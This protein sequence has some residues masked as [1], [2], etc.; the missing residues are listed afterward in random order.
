LESWKERYPHSPCEAVSF[1]YRDT[2]T[3]DFVSFNTRMVVSRPFFGARTLVAHG[4]P[5]PVL[6]LVGAVVEVDVT[7]EVGR[8]R[9][10]SV[11]IAV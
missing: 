1:R 2:V 8:G 11:G 4:S 10:V 9:G 5:P 3:A 6:L 7:F